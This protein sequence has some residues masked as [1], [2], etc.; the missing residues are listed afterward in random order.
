MNEL[1]SFEQN[2]SERAKGFHTFI[3]C[4]KIFHL[5]ILTGPMSLATRLQSKKHLVQCPIPGLYL[6]CAD[7]K[8]HL[9]MWM[10][11]YESCES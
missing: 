4:W 5:L 8:V 9:G 10:R 7:I 11:N 2:Q 6:L 3:Q 1:D